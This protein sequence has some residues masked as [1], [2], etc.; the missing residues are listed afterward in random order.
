VRARV[1]AQR[2]I[3]DAQ[4]IIDDER[5]REAERARVVRITALRDPVEIIRR[6]V[7]GYDYDRWGEDSPIILAASAWLKEMGK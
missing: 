2:A 7:D 4:R 3:D 5:R 1:L 6:L